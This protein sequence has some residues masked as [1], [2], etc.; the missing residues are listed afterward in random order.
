M[1]TVASVLYLICMLAGL[2]FYIMGET[3]DGCW[4]LLLAILNAISL[5]GL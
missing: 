5:D 2:V 1:K 4:F 3:L